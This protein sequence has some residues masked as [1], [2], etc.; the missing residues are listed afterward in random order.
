MADPDYYVGEFPLIL[1]RHPRA[2]HL[3]LRFEAKSGAALLTLPPG[4]PDRKAVQFAN[5]HH[6]WL[7]DQY[8]K[9]P[10]IT[11][12]TAGNAIPFRG[13]TIRIIHAPDKAAAVHIK[14]GLLTVGG[15]HA[16]FEKRLQNWLKKQARQALTEAVE[17]FKPLLG[18]GPHRI[19]VRDTT[20]RWG[21][22]SS[23]K[24]LSFSWRLIMAPPDILNYVVIH[25]MAH[26][27]EMN[28]GPAFWK[29]V[30]RLCPDWKSCR[31][32]LK[33]EGNALMLIG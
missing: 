22:C 1:R 26:L 19:M 12:L 4:I 17:N 28:H 33:S 31:R 18:Y 24:T 14:D 25:E 32:W 8:E 10:K 21:S 29:I 7:K 5:R 3:K 2:K 6:D 16:A 30:E 13:Q 20:S 9:S 27:V 15:H 23:R 11:A